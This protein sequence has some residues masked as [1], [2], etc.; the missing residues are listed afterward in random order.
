MFKLSRIPDA[1]TNAVAANPG[2]TVGEL[3]AEVVVLTTI[4]SAV[5][6]AEVVVKDMCV[7]CRGVTAPEKIFSLYFYLS[8][9][10][11]RI[12][13]MVCNSPQQKFGCSFK[14]IAQSKGTTTTV[15]GESCRV[16]SSIK[17]NPCGYGR[18]A[19]SYGAGDELETIR[20]E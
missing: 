8:A 11:K 17:A 10:G 12:I 16:H 1:V 19:R 13:G 18:D 9:R 2:D 4:P 14:L 7:S 6:F 15:R 20:S 5:K 3:G